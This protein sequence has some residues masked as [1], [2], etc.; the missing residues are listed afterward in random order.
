MS[1]RALITL[2]HAH[3]GSLMDLDP[4]TYSRPIRARIHFESEHIRYLK[5][6]QA[7]HGISLSAAIA[8]VIGDR[9]QFE[10]EFDAHYHNT[11][12]VMSDIAESEGC[13]T[14]ATIGVMAHELHN[15]GALKSL[16]GK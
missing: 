16:T 6:L 9:I 2:T 4:T 5:H 8:M 11:S 10:D 14:Y 7:A 15:S 13:S 3:G 1:K 12:A